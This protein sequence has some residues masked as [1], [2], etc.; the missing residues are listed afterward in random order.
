MSS[1]VDVVSICAC[2]QVGACQYVCSN[3]LVLLTLGV[4]AIRVRTCSSL[5]RLNQL[6]SFLGTHA[7]VSFCFAV[8]LEAHC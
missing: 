4:V 6:L 8:S 2:L 7:L 1:N 5:L 3:Y